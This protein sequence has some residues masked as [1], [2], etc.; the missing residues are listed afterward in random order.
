VVVEGVDVGRGQIVPVI[1]VVP[2][3]RT[4]AEALEL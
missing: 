3:E 1:I 2:R 4:L